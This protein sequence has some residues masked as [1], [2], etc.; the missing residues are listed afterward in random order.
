MRAERGYFILCTV[1]AVLAFLKI[2][3]LL[4]VALIRL[5]LPPGRGLRSG[6]EKVANKPQQGGYG[7]GDQLYVAFLEQFCPSG[8]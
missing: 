4:L 2:R 3:N 8:V 1:T 7:S 6:D 5:N